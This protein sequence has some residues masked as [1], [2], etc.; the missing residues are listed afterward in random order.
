MRATPDYLVATFLGLA[1]VLT[2][3]CGGDSTGPA[4]QAAPPTGV[5]EITVSTVSEIVDVDPD[6]YTL[7]IDG[8]LSYTV[9]VNATVR[10]GGL[11]TGSHLVRLDGL[12]ANCSVSGTNPRSVDVIADEAALPLSFSVECVAT[13]GKGDWD[14]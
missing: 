9:G 8:G 12:A 14:Y 11:P 4:G 2:P 10:I 5:I 3:G 13:T 1:A 7:S 6:G